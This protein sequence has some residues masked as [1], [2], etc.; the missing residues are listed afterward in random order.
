MLQGSLF[1][2][3]PAVPEPSERV[4]A[5]PAKTFAPDPLYP[6]DTSWLERQVEAEIREQITSLAAAEAFVAALGAN[7]KRAALINE[8]LA[9]PFWRDDLERLAMSI[10][11]QRQVACGCHE[12]GT[13][14]P[15]KKQ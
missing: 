5:A 11:F 8:R 6:A 3:L 7:C 10:A 2:L 13:F 4:V 14:T 12:I 1:D 15:L 9:H